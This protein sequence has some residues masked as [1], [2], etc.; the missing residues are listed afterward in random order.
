MA[1]GERG[2]VGKEHREREECG[3]STVCPEGTMMQGFA[4]GEAHSNYNKQ[5]AEKRQN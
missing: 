4:E 3:R 1:E 5:R 2:G